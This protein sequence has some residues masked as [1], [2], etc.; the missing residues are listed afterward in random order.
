MQTEA[1]VHLV[2]AHVRFVAAR[3][4]EAIEH[5]RKAGANSN[6]TVDAWW[7]TANAAAA[8][9][10]RQALAD[11]RDAFLSP[12][13]FPG[14]SR[15]ALHAVAS[16]ALAAREGRWDDVHSG[17]GPAIGRLAAWARSRMPTWRGLLWDA[18]RDRRRRLQL[19]IPS[20]RLAT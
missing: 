10:V 20:I 9:D 2:W 6:F 5:G 8:A 13:N 15:E 1:Y 18:C 14:P 4:D 17:F 19:I 3:W 12:L 11:A 16:A 7:V